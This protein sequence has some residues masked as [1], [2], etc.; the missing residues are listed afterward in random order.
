MKTYK[1]Y[2]DDFC[3]SIFHEME[4]VQDGR[5]GHTVRFKADNHKQCAAKICARLTDF[6]ASQLEEE[7]EHDL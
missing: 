7:Q 1:I 6:I 5:E 4:R 2:L 3:E